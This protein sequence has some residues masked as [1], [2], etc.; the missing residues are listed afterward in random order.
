MPQAAT[1][2]LD[3]G[4]HRRRAL[5]GRSSQLRRVRRKARLRPGPVPGPVVFRGVRLG[6]PIC[7]DIW[8]A[9][10]GR[11]LGRD[12]RGNPADRPM[13]RPIGAA[14]TTS[15]SASPRRGWSRAA[16]RWSISIRSADRTNWC[17]TAAVLCSMPIGRS[18]CNCRLS[19]RRSPK[20][21]CERESGAGAASRRPMRQRSTR[22]QGRLR[23]LRARAARLCAEKQFSRRGARHVGRRRFGALRRAGGGRAGADER[24]L[25]SCCPIAYTSRESL[26]DA[27]AMRRGSRACAMTSCRSPPPSRA[28]RR[29]WRRCSPGTPRGVTEENI[30]ARARGMILMSV[31]NKFGPMLVTTGNK[32]EMSVGYATLY[33]DMN[34]GFNPIKDLYKTQ[35]FRLSRIAQPL[36]AGGRARARWAGDPAKHHLQ[37]RRP[38]N[39]AKTRRIR[40]RCRPMT[41]ST[42]CWNVWSKRKCASPTLSCAGT[43]ADTVRKIERL[44]YLR[45]IQAPPVG[46]GRKGDAE[47]FRP[48]PALSRSSIASA[49]SGAPAQGPDFSIA[50]EAQLGTSERFED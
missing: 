34:G 15:A 1:L 19:P 12:R 26:E 38:P 37:N 17:S 14:R 43:I 22:R 18:R 35:V 36:E 3:G 30:Q 45:G 50:P 4:T 44:L 46:A 11:S 47:E 9:G 7:E 31:S 39:C 40:I 21:L 49:I 6:V 29:R 2:L 48:R 42:T 5:Q 32:S 16:C 28:S 33:G 8:G 41:R 13:A 27:A 10:R 23:R 20:V 24:P 25:R